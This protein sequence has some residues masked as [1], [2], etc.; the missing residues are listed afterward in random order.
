MPLIPEV[1]A[2]VDHFAG[3]LA[4]EVRPR[5]PGQDRRGPYVDVEDLVPFVLRLGLVEGVMV[6]TVEV[7]EVLA[8]L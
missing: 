3:P 5:G 7:R 1:L 6:R 4:Q 8:S 2:D